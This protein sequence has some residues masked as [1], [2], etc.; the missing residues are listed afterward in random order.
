MT[1]GRLL[2][3]AGVLAGLAFVLFVGVAIHEFDYASGHAYAYGPAKV[4]AWAAIAGAML[5]A[6]L[7]LLILAI[8]P[9][10]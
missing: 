3:V 5:A 7:G 8:V 6:A 4:I 1:R 10:D 2:T 9:K